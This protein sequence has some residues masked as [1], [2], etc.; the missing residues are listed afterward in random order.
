MPVTAKPAPE[1]LTIPPERSA[2]ASMQQALQAK[3]NLLGMHIGGRIGIG[4]RFLET[5]ETAVTDIE[6]Y[7]MA[8]TYKVAMEG[9][10]LS[11]STRAI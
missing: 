3:A 10:L 2:L 6:S 7:P 5:G 11:R 8:S 1:C 9:A 4:V